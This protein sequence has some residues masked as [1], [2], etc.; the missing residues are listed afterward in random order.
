MD[1]MDQD[2]WLTAKEAAEYLRL[3]PRWGFM[4][5]RKWV[6]EGKIK[7]ARVGRLYRFHKQ[8]LDDFAFSKR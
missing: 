7:S 6:R 5:I 3:S 8:D 2:R 4:T 1:Q